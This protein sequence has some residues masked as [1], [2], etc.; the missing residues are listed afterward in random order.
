MTQKKKLKKVLD[1]VHAHFWARRTQEVIR[2]MNFDIKST[3]VAEK[4]RRKAYQ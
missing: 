3:L 2:E 1:P 4:E